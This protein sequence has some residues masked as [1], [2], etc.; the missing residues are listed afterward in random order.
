M[1]GRFL[2]GVL[3]GGI[4]G[5]ALVSRWDELSDKYPVLKEMQAGAFWDK[6]RCHGAKAAKRSAHG[7]TRLMARRHRVKAY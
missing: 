6:T 3:V 5:A 7:R 1:E 2:K 4:L